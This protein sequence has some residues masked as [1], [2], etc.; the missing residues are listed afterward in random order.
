[1]KRLRYYVEHGFKLLE[2]YRDGPSRR[3][4]WRAHYSR[5]RILHRMARRIANLGKRG[6]NGED[7][8]HI[9]SNLKRTN[10]CKPILP[11]NERAKRPPEPSP[12]KHDIVFIIGDLKAAHA[13]GFSET[14]MPL[15]KLC[16]ILIQG[17][18]V[19]SVVTTKEERTSQ[20]CNFCYNQGTPSQLP[21]R[22]FID[23]RE[24]YRLKK[25]SQCN[26]FWHR[27]VVAALNI[28]DVWL[29]ENSNGGKRPDNFI[30]GYKGHLNK[31]LPKR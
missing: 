5:E 13:E 31:Q 28:R 19:R 26:K 6:E 22:F 27:D 14:S 18:Y 1:M 30:R 24:R 20:E 3:D 11:V 23:G 2:A 17:K 7:L 12:Q 29:Y 10:R 15:K 25:C 4:R 21:I 16:N 8:E 9:R